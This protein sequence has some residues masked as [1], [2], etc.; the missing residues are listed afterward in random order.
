MIDFSTEFGKHAKDRLEREE[1]GW[2]ITVGSDGTPQPSPVWFLWDGETIL[3][4]SRPDTPKVRNVR[5]HPQ[6]A[7]HLDG[8]EQ[9]GNIVIL[10][11]EVTI[12]DTLPADQH[13]AYLEKYAAPIIRIGLTNESF[14]D[15]YS[16]PLRFRPTRLRGF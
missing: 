14:A 7:F 8:D 5:R 1:V 9:G 2:L 12:D 10:I 4:Y 16:T 3:I 11:G 15:G 13:S 6:T